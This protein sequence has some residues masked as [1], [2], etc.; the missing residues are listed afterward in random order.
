MGQQPTSPLP[1]STTLY[2]IPST[3]T[4]VYFSICKSMKDKIKII[5][6]ADHIHNNFD[7]DIELY[8][9][10]LI[11]LDFLQIDDLS[12]LFLDYLM[13]EEMIVYDLLLKFS[14]DLK[15][16]ILLEHSLIR[17]KENHPTHLYSHSHRR[18]PPRPME[19]IYTSLCAPPKSF[20]PKRDV[21]EIIFTCTTHNDITSA[22]KI[23]I[24][25]AKTILSQLNRHQQSIFIGCQFLF[26]QNYFFEYHIDYLEGH[27]DTISRYGYSLDE[28]LYEKVTL[29]G[30]P[31]IP[32]TR[33]VVPIFYE[34]FY[35]LVQINNVLLFEQS[36]LYG[37][38]EANRSDINFLFSCYFKLKQHYSTRNPEIL[39]LLKKS[40]KE[41]ERM[42]NR[43][44]HQYYQ[45][46]D[47][48][49]T[50]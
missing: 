16:H 46:P 25:L 11:S 44:F 21:R 41:T 42:F 3:F 17:I 15:N 24:P 30:L 20:P 34:C 12:L 8:T 35:F 45:I 47:I 10:S 13:A 32:T 5:F 29:H 50:V 28:D 43:T 7:T 37:R 22:N 14:I 33:K 31:V 40:L 49:S 23:D 39:L 36:Y 19:H 27:R 18:E 6:T 9:S 2:K 48:L 1:P 4:I 38:G 26:F